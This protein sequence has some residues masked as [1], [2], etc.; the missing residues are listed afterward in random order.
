[1]VE[2]AVLVTMIGLA[3][4][5]V[6]LVLGELL[7]AN[8]L[9]HQKLGG[10]SALL[11]LTVLHIPVLV[12]TPAFRDGG[13]PDEIGVLVQAGCLIAASIIARLPAITTWLK[14]R[15]S[16]QAALYATSPR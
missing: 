10:R 4:I 5:S 16:P 1:D 6:L 9:R 12:V 7:S 14:S 8:K 13:R 15:R 3:V 11:F 2:T